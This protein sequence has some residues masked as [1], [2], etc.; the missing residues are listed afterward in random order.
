GSRFLILQDV[1]KRLERAFQ[2]FYRRVKNREPAGYPRFKSKSRY[3]SF[4]LPQNGWRVE[5]DKLFISK[6]GSVRIRLSRPIEGKV[7]TL[8][9]KREQDNWFVIFCCDVEEKLL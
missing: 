7:K 6:I 2:S 4:T 9:I 5:G 8:T 1:L 3:N